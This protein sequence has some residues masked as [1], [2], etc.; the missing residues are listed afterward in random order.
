MSGFTLKI[1]ALISMITD[2]IGY[3]F[4][5]DQV[6]LR[7]VG[8]LAFPLYAFLIAQGFRNTSDVRKYMLRLAIFA[9]VSEAPFDLVISG[10]VFSLEQQNVFFTLFF[11]LMAITLYDRFSREA[12]AGKAMLPVLICALAATLA[13]SDYGFYGVLMIFVFYV[14]RDRSLLV[15]WVFLLVLA[16]V[17]LCYLEHCSLAWS[18]VQLFE[19]GA[20]PM[21]LMYNGKRG[22]KL[23]YFFYAAYPAH[24]MAIYLIVAAL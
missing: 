3:A 18:V 7:A 20:L 5:P 17:L 23:K 12:I 15:K 4:F 14:C 13:G 11:G 8:R 10:R 21:V 22:R 24:L 2:H 19:L 9:V 6:W 16:D 1:I